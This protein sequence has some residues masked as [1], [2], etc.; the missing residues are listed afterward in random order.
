MNEVEAMLVCQR[1]VLTSPIRARRLT[2]GVSLET[3]MH[4]IVMRIEA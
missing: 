4:G 3:Q 1:E 2:P